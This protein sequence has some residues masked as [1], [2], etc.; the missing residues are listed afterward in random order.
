MDWNQWIL[1][2]GITGE[3]GLEYALFGQ[4]K[5]NLGVDSFLRRGLR[6]V[7]SEWD[8]VCAAF[9]LKKLLVGLSASG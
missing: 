4:I 3:F 8:L 6:A 7:K 1:C 5:K 2:A 9:N